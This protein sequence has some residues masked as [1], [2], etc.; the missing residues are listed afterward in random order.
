MVKRFSKFL[1]EQ[2]EVEAIKSIAE[3]MVIFWYD[4][5]DIDAAKLALDVLEEGQTYNFSKGYHAR[6]DLGLQPNQQDH[7]HV[8]LRKNHLCVINKDG[9]ASHKSD[10]S[11]IP[12]HVK[13][14]I[15]KLGVVTLA[16]SM[17]TEEASFDQY[18][19]P[20]AALLSFKLHVLALSAQ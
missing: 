1:A 18:S 6:F 9:T 10:L 8:Y 5:A 14:E 15:R 19:V 7:L 3:P 17:L 2:K 11:L 16:E 4:P 12:K 20:K 13:A